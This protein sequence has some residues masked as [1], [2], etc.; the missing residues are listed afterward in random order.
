M[1][2]PAFLID[3]NI[4]ISAN[5]SLYPPDL[6]PS[7]WK[8]MQASIENGDI[9]IL[10]VV[11][12]EIEGCRDELESWIRD[13]DFAPLDHNSDRIVECYSSIANY[14]VRRYPEK[15]IS[16]LS[17]SACADPWLISFAMANGG[18][19]VTN[20]EAVPENSRKVKIPNIAG[21]F[22]IRCTDHIGMMRSLG[23]V[24]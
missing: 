13:I 15:A 19:I 11:K 23:Y 18:I 6:F 12:E 5:N 16:W 4:L 3:T 20:E 24:F 9:G 14:I 17:S 8:A 22:G 7:F 21:H 2:S 1:M 10:R